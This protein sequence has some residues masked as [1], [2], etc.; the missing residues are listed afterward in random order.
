MTK[1]N[2]LF[3]ISAS[4]LFFVLLG[5]GIFNYQYQQIKN[6][7][8]IKIE[9]NKNLLKK[10]DELQK[11]IEELKIFKEDPIN[12]ITSWKTYKNE[13]QGFEIELPSVGEWNYDIRIDRIDEQ[14]G[15]ASFDGQFNVFGKENNINFCLLPFVFNLSSTKYLYPALPKKNNAYSA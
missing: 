2:I 12:E 4:L 10:I 6:K 14:T 5:T 13:Q 9:E 15:I 3:I 11:E 8:A 1:K 7:L